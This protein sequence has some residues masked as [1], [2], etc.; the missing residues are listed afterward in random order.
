MPQLQVKKPVAVCFFEATK[1]S[2]EHLG[3]WRLDLAQRGAKVPADVP[4]LYAD[5]RRVRDYLHRSTAGYGER[6][7]L[8]IDVTDVAVLVACFLHAL[9][10]LDPR[11]ETAGNLDERQSLEKKHELYCQWILEL[12]ER[13]L[14]ELPMRREHPPS[15]ATRVLI[16]RMQSKVFGEAKHR[17]LFKQWDAGGVSSMMLGLPSFGDSVNDLEELPPEGQDKPAR[18][19]HDLNALLDDDPDSE[20]QLRTSAD[21]T[22]PPATSDAGNAVA[23]PEA[24]HAQPPDEPASAAAGTEPARPVTTVRDDVPDQ[25]TL[26]DPHKVR[27]PRLRAMLA[28]DLASYER[29]FLANDLRVATVLMVSV[30]EAVL[31]DHVL[32]RRAEFG[33]TGT[34]DAWNLSD[35][36]LRALGDQATSQDRALAHQLFAARNLVRPAMQIVAPT[37]VTVGSFWALREFVQRTLHALGYGAGELPPGSFPPR[38]AAEA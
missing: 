16:A 5:V 10:D 12:A 33:V 25:P 29:T 30:L 20:Q 26:F 31:L 27:D 13:P 21:A 19:L 38:A 14:I 4:R 37:V 15:T 35:L 11:I 6:V 2:L 7:D 32:A 18:T 36:L 28:L 22:A 23:A 1:T 9:D 17:A 8:D 34:P 24:Q 3:A